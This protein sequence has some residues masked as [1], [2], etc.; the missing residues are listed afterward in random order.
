MLTKRREEAVQMIAERRQAADDVAADLFKLEMA[1]D[2]AVCCA[3]RLASRIPEARLRAKVSA[4]E[5]QDAVSLVGEAL[6]SLL[7][8]RGKAVAAHHELADLHKKVLNTPYAS[9]DLWKFAQPKAELL[10]LASSRKA[11]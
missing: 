2:E 5:D 10:T 6:T 1:L 9:G 8:A 3:G 4:V 7:A 11:A